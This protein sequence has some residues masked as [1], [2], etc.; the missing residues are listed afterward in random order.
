MRERLGVWLGVTE[1]DGEAERVGVAVLVGVWDGEAVLEVLREVL[2][3]AEGLGEEEIGELVG[4]EEAP[5]E[6]ELVGVVLGGGEV[7]DVGV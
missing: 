3:A 4:E 1:R 2:A 7:D 6:L 5:G